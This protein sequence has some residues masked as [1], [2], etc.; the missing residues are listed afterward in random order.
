MRITPTTVPDVLLVDLDVFKDPRGLFFE[1]H[2]ESRYRENGIPQTF[3]Q[4]NFS[5]ST[6]GVLRGLHYQVGHPQ[7][8]LVTVLA[9]RVFDVAVDIRKRSPTFGRWVGVELSGETPQQLYIPP[10]FAHGFCVLS[11]SADFLYK[12][13]DV[14][15][16]AG[17]RGLIWNDPALAITWPV[18]AP[19]LSPKDQSFRTLREM[20]SELPD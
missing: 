6:K 10:G 2:R 4:D 18:T 19:L 16:P 13:T 15:A 12:C 8:K 7:G 20:E 17:E 11:E 14:Y 3:V 1:I 9:G 5:R